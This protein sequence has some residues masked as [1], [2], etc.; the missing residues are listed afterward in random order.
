MMKNF[1]SAN[2]VMENIEKLIL[3]DVRFD[4]HDPLYGKKEYNKNHIEGAYYLDLNNDLSG[5]KNDDGH[6]GSRP[7]PSLK[8]FSEKIKKFGIKK[9]SIIVFYDEDNI[10]SSR[11][12]IIF[13]YFNI[14]NVKVLDGGINSWLKINGSLTNKISEEKESTIE[15][16]E[17]LEMICDIEYIKEKKELN[18]VVLVEGREYER[19]LGK[20]EPFYKKAGHIPLA[21]CIPVD[22]VLDNNDMLKNKNELELVFSPLKGKDEVIFYCGSG[23][24]AALT[25]LAY[26]EIGGK[27]K[28]YIGGFSDWISYDE[29]PVETKDEN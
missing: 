5:K 22:S 18:S 29:N 23:V 14:T 20:I 4:M 28:I 12:S 11:A 10:I 7:V 6:G 19:Y 26:D 9:E 2:W 25:F 17:H 3:I 24:N 1:V 15:L 21:K 16:E 8:E 27:S 13:R